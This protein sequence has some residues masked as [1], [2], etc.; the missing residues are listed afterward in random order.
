MP[1]TSIAA[2]FLVA[3]FSLALSG[4]DD[5]D[6]CKAKSECKR[7]GKCT[8]DQRGVCTVG[9]D[10]DCKG[11]ATCKLHGKCS[12]KE[13]ACIATSDADCKASEDCQKLG[14]CNAYQGS[15]VDLAKSVHAE[16]TKT[17]RARAC[18]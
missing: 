13:G 6:A 3:V 12:A 2:G 8:P 1:R 14:S 7:D 4:C 5:P 18:A 16:C 9:S 10:Q 11:R 15:C 17:C